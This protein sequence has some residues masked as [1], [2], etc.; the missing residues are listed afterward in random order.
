MSD[1]KHRFKILKSSALLTVAIQD[2]KRGGFVVF[3]IALNLN[4]GGLELW[5]L[6]LETYK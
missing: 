6:E 2:L 5:G 3:Y 1:R 4:A